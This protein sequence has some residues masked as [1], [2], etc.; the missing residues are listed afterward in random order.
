MCGSGVICGDQ[1][2]ILGARNSGSVYSC[3]L[4]DLLQ[5]RQTTNECMS[6]VAGQQ[7]NGWRQLADLPFYY[8]T[9][10]SLVGRL[11]A[12][13][14]NMSPHI[15]SESTNSVYAYKK[16]ANS[17]EAIGQM[18]LAR[19]LCFAIALHSSNELMVVGGRDGLD[20]IDSVEFASLVEQ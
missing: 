9:C 6:T 15:L 11:L 13:G 2:Y 19:R 10:I 12:V 4:S 1:L 8:S 18:F 7:F 17:W 5:S 3:T 20:T 16:T 14:G